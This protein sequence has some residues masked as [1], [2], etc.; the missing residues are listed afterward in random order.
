MT[1]VELR[2]VDPQRGR[3]GR[4]QYWYFRRNGRRWKLP[5]TPLSVEFME[6]YRD[7][8]AETD[9]AAQLQ[10]ERLR[11]G[12]G[13]F[14]ALVRDY[15]ASSEF[16]EKKDSTR[17]EYRRV[18]EALAERHGAKPV[19]DLKR[20]HVRKMKDERAETPGAANTIVR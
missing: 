20:R 13:S 4:V 19:R 3:D 1:Q 6:A 12:P 7:L 14:G 15:L 16:K 17:A 10:T 9:G 2:Y 11:H 5:G 8:I 18:L